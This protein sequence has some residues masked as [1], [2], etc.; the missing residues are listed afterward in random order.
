MT[1]LF[2]A[3]RPVLYCDDF[4]KTS[5]LG[6]DREPS[7][8]IGMFEFLILH[9]LRENHGNDQIFRTKIDWVN[10]D[11]KPDKGYMIVRLPDMEDRCKYYN[12]S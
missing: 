9:H 2:F 11:R 4:I 8:Y 7:D 3:I 10:A 1:E 6:K 12:P 5:Y